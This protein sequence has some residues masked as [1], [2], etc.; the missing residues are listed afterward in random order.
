MGILV[1]Q[2]T[3]ISQPGRFC[4]GVA[5]CRSSGGG[6]A[7][8][9]QSR[10]RILA[11]QWPSS[12]R[13]AAEYVECA[14]QGC[15]RSSEKF[16]GLVG[17]AR[18]A[19]RA[20]IPFY[21]CPC[22]PAAP[23]PPRRPPSLLKGLLDFGHHWFSKLCKLR[24]CLAAYGLPF[25]QFQFAHDNEYAPKK[26]REPEFVV[27]A[28]EYSI[29]EGKRILAPYVLQSATGIYRGMKVRLESLL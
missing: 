2:W 10:C 22:P 23:A 28:V 16:Y 7:V 18:R 17:G 21:W 13:A 20:K 24:Q 3:H 12:G 1:K 8:V 26:I 19:R 15:D 29:E 9:A 6:Q 27:I 11:E 25:F 5:E 14:T 4:K